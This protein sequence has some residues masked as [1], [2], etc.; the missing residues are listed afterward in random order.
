M[1]ETNI[2]IDNP[3]TIEV[4]DETLVKAIVKDYITKLIT[5]AKKLSEENP[6]TLTE[7]FIKGSI[8]G[9]PIY[10]LNLSELNHY[11]R[12]LSNIRD[13][14]TEH[15]NNPKGFY[16]IFSEYCNGCYAADVELKK[17]MEELKQ[18]EE[19]VEICQE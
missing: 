14:I 13:N 9:T 16:S 10:S 3:L 11:D 4:E 7:N 15:P 12:R 8:D 1:T 17:E 19:G 5:A 2:R 18:V 6:E